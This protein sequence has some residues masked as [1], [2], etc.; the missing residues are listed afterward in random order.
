M[1]IWNVILSMLNVI[2][3]I[4]CGYCSKY[5]GDNQ[6]RVLNELYTISVLLKNILT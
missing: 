4:F 1:E 2:G 5:K 3:T 6:A